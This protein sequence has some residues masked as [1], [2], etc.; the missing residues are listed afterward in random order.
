MDPEQSVNPL[1]YALDQLIERLDCRHVHC[2]IRRVTAC[3][4]RADCDCVKSRQFV[5]EQTALQTGMNRL[6]YKLFAA[7][8]LPDLAE[9]TAQ[10]RFRIICPSGVSVVRFRFKAQRFCK[11][12]KLRLRLLL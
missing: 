11:Q 8:L 9:Q 10:G 6:R 12:A 3:A 7:L 4:A 1:Q 5:A 2:L